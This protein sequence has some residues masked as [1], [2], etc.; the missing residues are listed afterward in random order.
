[1]SSNDDDFNQVTIPPGAYEID[2]LN[3]GI[4][5]NIIEEGYFTKAK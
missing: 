1:M 4:K 5:R 2:S 3:N